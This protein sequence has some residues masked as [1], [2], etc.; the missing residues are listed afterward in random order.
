MIP[1]SLDMLIGEMAQI[2]RESTPILPC[3][4][5][6]FWDATLRIAKTL[7][8]EDNRPL[9]MKQMSPKKNPK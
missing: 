8:A 3:Y 1:P 6:G 2:F 7:E 5:L 9:K 4:P